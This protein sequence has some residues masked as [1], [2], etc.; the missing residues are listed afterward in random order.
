M[1]SWPD[2]RILDLFE[3]EVPIIQAPM[4]GSSTAELAMAVSDAG[5]LGS[6]PCAL[7][8]LEQMRAALTLIGPSTSRQLNLNFFCHPSPAVDSVRSLNWRAQ[9]APYYVE[10]GLDP[11][12][13]PPA[14]DRKP[15]DD[16][17]CN[18]VE[19]YRPAVVSFHFGLP[20][21]NLLERVRKAG[22]KVIS[23]AT[24]V[25][26]ARWLEQRGC[27]AVI[28]MGFEAGG[29]RGSFLAVDM[30]QQIGTFALV[31]QIADAV[32][33][34]IIAAGGIADARGIVAAFALGAAAVQIGTAY[35]FCPEV[36]LPRLYREALDG[37]GD[38][39]TMITN[40]FT[41]K[42]ARGIVNR[43]MREQGPL[44][45]L[46]PA[47]PSAAAAVTPLKV[48]AETLGRDDFSNL[49][50]GQAARLARR[51]L[52]AGELTRLLAQQALDKLSS[53]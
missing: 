43:L 52:P 51:S 42:P 44:S 11:E 49:W 27:D 1:Q 50:A 6:L 3:I 14:V 25:A 26:E 37:V 7:L 48:K 21:Q 4:A 23:S 47:F 10:L 40:V 41:G 13:V 28:A 53:F 39:N 34:P 22:A 36:N 18:L 19:E 38:E 45:L 29:H 35:L 16:A 8:S 5:G 46:A 17:C 32:Q 2:R 12:A 31:P 33:I 9:L 30:S 24:T 20:S 15:F